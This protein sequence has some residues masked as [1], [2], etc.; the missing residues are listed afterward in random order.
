[1]D[2]D[3]QERAFALMEQHE[4][5]YQSGAITEAMRDQLDYYT[6]QAAISEQFGRDIARG[7]FGDALSQVGDSLSRAFSDTFGWLGSSKD[8]KK[9]EATSE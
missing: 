6:Q 2:P 5:W 3:I 8:K 7:D 4:S 1:M 9:D